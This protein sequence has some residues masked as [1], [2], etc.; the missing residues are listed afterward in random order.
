[1]SN[2]NGIDAKR[3]AD[4]I[5]AAEKRCGGEIV[6]VIAMESDPYR[7]I[8]ILWS[9]LAALLVPIP[10]WLWETGFGLF[11]VHALQVLVFASLS[12]SLSWR[13]LKMLVIPKG[14][15][16][17]RARR[18]AREQFLE[19]RLPAARHAAGVL[20]FASLAEHYVEVIADESLMGRVAQEEWDGIISD[21]TGEV[22]AGRITE[23]FLSAIADCEQ[24]LAKLDLD[25]R[26]APSELPN[27]LIEI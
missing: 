11:E 9:A 12:L 26:G 3:I 24:I 15:K 5:S 10:F 4:A 2:Q 19:Q 16:Q 27:H 14:V 20:L 22:R 18:R 21:F 13:P 8:P 25:P 1:L 17:V 7:F 23:G 6:T